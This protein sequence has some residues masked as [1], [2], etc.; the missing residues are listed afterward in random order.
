MNILIVSLDR[1]SASHIFLIN[2]LVV[3]YEVQFCGNLY[4]LLPSIFMFI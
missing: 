3:F 4:I 2:R 1:F